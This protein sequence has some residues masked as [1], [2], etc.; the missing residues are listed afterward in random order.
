MSYW[1]QFAATGDPG[2]G[3]DGSLPLWSEWD[4]ADNGKKFIIL[5]TTGGGGLR[6][7]PG[8]VTQSEVL[9]AAEQDPSLSERKDRCAIL[10]QIVQWS[11]VELPEDCEYM[12]L[13][14]ESAGG[15]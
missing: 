3:R 1:V 4:S 10:D 7:A 11:D 13:G 9:A 15:S 12:S 6:M 8:S 14:V 2:R 5:D